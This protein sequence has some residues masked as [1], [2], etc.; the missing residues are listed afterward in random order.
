LTL[1][2]TFQGQPGKLAP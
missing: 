1:T 2:D